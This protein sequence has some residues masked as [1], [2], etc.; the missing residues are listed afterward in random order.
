MYNQAYQ[1][2]GG[3]NRKFWRSK[4]NNFLGPCCLK[5]CNSQE[6]F[7]DHYRALLQK[8]FD[9]FFALIR[10]DGEAIHLAAIEQ[11]CDPTTTRFPWQSLPSV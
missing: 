6:P 5:H 11:F 7:S 2:I 1:V 10:L 4:T 3:R 9:P 8:A